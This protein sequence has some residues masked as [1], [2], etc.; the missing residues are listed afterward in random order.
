[1]KYKRKR[2]RKVIPRTPLSEITKR[3]VELIKQSKEYLELQRPTFEPSSSYDY[4]IY[5]DG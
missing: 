4:Y 2:K 5:P 1:M 3:N